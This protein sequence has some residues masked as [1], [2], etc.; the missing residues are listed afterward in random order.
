MGGGGAGGTLWGQL[1]PDV[2]LT[3]AWELRDR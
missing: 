2:L 3:E 1:S